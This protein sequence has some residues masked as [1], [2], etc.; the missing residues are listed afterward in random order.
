MSLLLHRPHAQRTLLH[1]V[2]VALFGVPR[3]V[4]GTY[5]R[6][7]T[8]NKG[9]HAGETKVLAKAIES[10]ITVLNAETEEYVSMEL[11]QKLLDPD[12][13]FGVQSDDKKMHEVHIPLAMQ[14]VEV[15]FAGDQKAQRKRIEDA[16]AIQRKYRDDLNTEEGV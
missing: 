4:Q 8:A 11:K 10:N 3:Q 15:L 16:L 6:A 14:S 5:V 12:F 13:Q 1:E 7:F 2:S 9:D